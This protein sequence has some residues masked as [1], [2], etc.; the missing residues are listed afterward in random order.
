[1]VP[2]G[3]ARLAPEPPMTKRKPGRKS[4][5]RINPATTP[6]TAEF[7]EEGRRSHAE[8]RRIARE[9]GLKIPPIPPRRPHQPWVH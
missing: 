6:G 8:L 4:R 9:L 5:R 3:P 2:A 7:E 1:M